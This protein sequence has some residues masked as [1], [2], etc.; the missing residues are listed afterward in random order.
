MAPAE[1]VTATRLTGGSVA[2][3]EAAAT[4]VNARR[5]A[6]MRCIVAGVGVVAAGATDRACGRPSCGAGGS[7]RGCSRWTLPGCRMQTSV[8]SSA[9]VGNTFCTHTR[10]TR[11]ID[12]LPGASAL[13]ADAPLRMPQ[14]PKTIQ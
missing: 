7:L 13:S 4:A 9:S 2:A 6:A 1:P 10:H 11:A 8:T 12:S 5:A 14:S 3:G